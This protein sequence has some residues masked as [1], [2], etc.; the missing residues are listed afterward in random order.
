MADITVQHGGNR[1]SRARGGEVGPT[2]TSATADCRALAS[3]SN[4]GRDRRGG[5]V[6]PTRTSAIDRQANCRLAC[7]QLT[8]ELVDVVELVP[9]D[10]LQRIDGQIAEEVLVAQIAEDSVE[11]FNLVPQEQF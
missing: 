11:E 1:G 5:E 6:G 3:A 7:S 8:E 2:G 10:S 9:H 4:S